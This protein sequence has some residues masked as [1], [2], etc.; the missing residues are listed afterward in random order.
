MKIVYKNIL[1]LFFLIL[2]SLILTCGPKHEHPSH[3]PPHNMSLGHHRAPAPRRNGFD[4]CARKMP[5]SRKSQTP[6]EFLPVKSHEQRS[7]VG[8]S[9]W[10][11][12][13]V[14]HDLVIKQQQHVELK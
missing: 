8:Y 7:L 3:L 9:P 14:R 10:G 6:L 12:K 4:P 13:T 2:K 5:W 1:F 11:P